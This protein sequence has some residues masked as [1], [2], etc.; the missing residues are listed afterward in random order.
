MA[1][2]V[3]KYGG[4]SVG[5]IE[6]INAVADRVMH[7]VQQG[8]QV[9]VVV[10]AMAGE[11]NRLLELC[12]QLEPRPSAREKDVLVTAGEQVTA[13]LLSI[14]LVARGYSALS[15]LAD[16][17]GLKTSSQ[18][19]KARIENIEAEQLR[20]QVEHGRI[21]VVAG[22]QGRDCENNV[23]SLGR[24]GTDTSAVAIAAA[25][26]A[27]ECQIFT[28]VNGVYTTDP[29]IEKQARLLKTVSFDEMLELASLGAKVLQKRSVELAGKYRVPLRVLSSFIE[30][31]ADLQS[32]G[33]LITYEESELE[34]LLVT[35]IAA[36]KDEAMI[37]MTLP[38]VSSFES[39]EILSELAEHDIEI[40]MLTQKTNVTGGGQQLALS[41]TVHGDDFDSTMSLIEQH[42]DNDK[43]LS[44][45]IMQG[46]RS[47]AKISLVGVGLRS[48][49]GVLS[50]V[51]STL[52]D[53]HIPV[54]LVS[55]SEIKISVLIDQRYM[56]LGVRALH[57][58]FGLN[59]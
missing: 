6:R 25:L 54:L 14:A 42:F 47:V 55:T 32:E 28:D 4:T 53:E 41:F 52:A 22:F 19:G 46:Q 12:R 49:A 3:Q 1:L 39:A 11:T 16:Q 2:I 30:T 59:N 48:H 27:D 23:T 50:K 7:T 33:T 26:N 21:V 40:D 36:S 38:V 35:G 24:G 15:F 34:G 31:K 9:V 44:K 18:F 43:N 10:S 51:L 37:E 17:L 58:A 13:A 45:E 8:H 20:E 5:S 56:E 29:R 57:N